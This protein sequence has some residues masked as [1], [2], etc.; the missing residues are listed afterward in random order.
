MEEGK[1]IT[2]KDG[3]RILLK[4]KPIVLNDTNVYMNSKLRNKVSDINK[5]KTQKEKIQYINKTYENKLR[6]PISAIKVKKFW[7]GDKKTGKYDWQYTA[8]TKS[9]QMIATNSLEELDEKL[10]KEIYK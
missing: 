6:Y 5:I 3:R 4:P 2:L 8:N 10:K 9:G 1:W 7:T